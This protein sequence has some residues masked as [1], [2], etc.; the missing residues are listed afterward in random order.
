MESPSQGRSFLRRLVDLL[1]VAVADTR[2]PLSVTELAQRAE[3]PL[4]TASRLAGMLV[5][6]GMLRF[7]PDGR[8]DV[9]PEL[10]HL[11]ARALDRVRS[12]AQLRSAVKGLA[13]ATGESA[14]AGLLIGDAIVLV[15]RDEPEHSLR[16]V[17]QV[18]D[19]ISPHTSAMGKAI[20]A[21]L[22]P[23]RR[24]AVLR[25]AAGNDAEA[26]NRKLEA[27]LA[28]VYESGYAVD[29]GIFAVGLRCRAVALLDGTGRADGGIS[30]AGPASRFTYE[31][32]TQCL[33]RLQAI[34]TE[35]SPTSR[36]GQPGR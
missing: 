34:A 3:I 5:D 32:A 20:M 22:D 18:G 24:L 33:P 25:R 12:D 23:E 17:A 7:L 36:E 29:E 2:E 21:H 9:G 26:L 27:E 35:L 6:R 8:I 15:A 31:Q 28:E 4:S 10:V 19:L 1:V 16:A 30:V 14:S 13:A 11:A